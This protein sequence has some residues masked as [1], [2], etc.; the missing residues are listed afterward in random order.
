MCGSKVCQGLSW[1]VPS[2]SLTAL[3]SGGEPASRNIRESRLITY[4]R[5][6]VE[7]YKKHLSTDVRKVARD[8]DVVR[9]CS[10]NL[11]E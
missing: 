11:S 8:S 2:T 3:S 4:K 10:A 7:H 5:H 9:S 1:V 6:Y